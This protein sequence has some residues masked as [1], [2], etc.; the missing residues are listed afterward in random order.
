[1]SEKWVEAFKQMVI[2][3]SQE[4]VSLL[5]EARLT[6]SLIIGMIDSLAVEREPV[7]PNCHSALT[8]DEADNG[9]G[10]QYSPW[11]CDNCSGWTVEREPVETDAIELI[12]EFYANED[13]I[14]PRQIKE[15]KEQ[16]EALRRAG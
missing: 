8:R 10:I 14:D 9:V 15:A 6:P 3:V 4:K 12:L 16:L 11:R 7:C 2:E 13:K 1:M 5:G